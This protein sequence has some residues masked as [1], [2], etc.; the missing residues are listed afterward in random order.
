[1]NEGIFKGSRQFAYA[2]ATDVMST[3]STTAFEW[4]VTLSSYYQ[5]VGIASQLKPEDESIRKY[6]QNAIMY[7]HSNLPNEP[8][9]S[10]GQDMIHSKL[11]TYNPGDV[12][13]FTFQPQRKKFVIDLEVS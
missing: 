5:I 8:S 12:I 6:D 4:N 9:I 1:M 3:R 10:I 11:P 2:R 7:F 13:R